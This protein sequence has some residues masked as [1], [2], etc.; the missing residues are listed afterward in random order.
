MRAAL[1]S[2]VLTCSISFVCPAEVEHPLSAPSSRVQHA[3]GCSHTAWT[4][5][6]GITYQPGRA[7]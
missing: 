6:G 7:R 4:I 2:V 1:L 5:P 3:L